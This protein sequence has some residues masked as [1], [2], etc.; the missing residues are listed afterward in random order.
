MSSGDMPL[1]TAVPPQKQSGSRH[2]DVVHFVAVD[3]NAGVGYE[4]AGRE[5]GADEPFLGRLCFRLFG[6][7]L[8]LLCSAG[9]TVVVIGLNSSLA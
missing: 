4:G 5:G 6:V 9:E 7:C 2:L 8:A 3:N 1:G